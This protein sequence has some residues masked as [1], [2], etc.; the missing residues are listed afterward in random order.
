MGNYF[1]DLRINVVRIPDSDMHLRSRLNILL[2]WQLF[3]NRVFHEIVR[4]EMQKYYSPHGRNITERIVKRALK[5]YI[6]HMFIFA[7]TDNVV[8]DEETMIVFVV[9]FVDYENDFINLCETACIDIDINIFDDDD[10]IHRSCNSRDTD[11]QKIRNENKQMTVQL[12]NKYFNYRSH[13]SYSTC[14]ECKESS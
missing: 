8:F 6:K 9:H 2:Q 7:L 4:K 13:V 12:L 11:T 3:H 5:S 14:G 10:F 1:S